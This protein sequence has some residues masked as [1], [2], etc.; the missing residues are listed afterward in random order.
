MELLSLA[1]HLRPMEFSIHPSVRLAVLFLGPSQP[2]RPPHSSVLA[3]TFADQT[4]GTP[5]PP[6][7][8]L[9]LG[10]VFAQVPFFLLPPPLRHPTFDPIFGLAS[11]SPGR[12]LESEPRDAAPIHLQLHVRQSAALRRADATLPPSQHVFTCSATPSFPHSPCRVSFVHE[13]GPTLLRKTASA[14]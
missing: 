4:T 5:R 6:C 13:A 12:L 10:H 7:F 9:P 14:P 11:T 1:A 2:K 8:A 3:H